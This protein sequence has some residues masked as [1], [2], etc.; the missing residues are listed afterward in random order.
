MAETQPVDWAQTRTGEMWSLSS[1]SHLDGRVIAARDFSF[2]ADG[3]KI[4]VG[5]RHPWFSLNLRERFIDA[6]KFFLLRFSCRAEKQG[7][8]RLTAVSPSG[9]RSSCQLPPVSTQWQVVEADLT[10]IDWQKTAEGGWGGMEGLVQ[11]MTFLA[12]FPVGVNCAV[13]MKD[14]FLLGEGAPDADPPFIEVLPD[15]A[16]RMR[17]RITD[18]S[19]V[20]ERGIL[21]AVNGVVF[22]LSCRALAWDGEI[23]TC[24]PRHICA[25]NL[26][27]YVEAQDREGHRGCAEFSRPHPR[28]GK[29]TVAVGFPEQEKVREIVVRKGTRA[30]Y[31]IEVGNSSEPVNRYLEIHGEVEHPK[32]FVKGGV[33]CETPASVVKSI[34]SPEMS[35]REKAFAIWRWEMAHAYSVGVANPVDRTKYMNVFGYGYCSSHAQSVQALCEAADLP[36][37]FLKYRLP[38]GHGTTQFFFDGGWHMLDSHQR[39]YLLTRDGRT[40]ASAE[41]IEGDPE[42][43]CPGRKDI[44]NY[45]EDQ[46]Y[47]QMYYRPVDI[48]PIHETAVY[49]SILPGSMSQRLR[50]GERLILGW[51]GEGRWAHAPCEPLD[52][53]NG[54][55]VFAPTLTRE[56]VAEEAEEAEHLRYLPAGG[57][58]AEP[59][60][61]LSYLMSSAYLMVGGRVDIC[62]EAAEPAEVRFSVS[63]DGQRWDSFGS[64]RVDG[65][66]SVQADFSRFLS[67]RLVEADSPV[68]RDV[69]E[70]RVRIEPGPKLWMSALAI[71]VDLQM[72]PRSLPALRQGTNRCIFS[73]DRRNGPVRIVHRWE[74]PAGLTSSNPSPSA[75]EEVTLTATVR[76]DEQSAQGPFSVQLYEG[77]PDRD[78]RPI[79]RPLRIVRIPPGATVSVSRRWTAVCRM[80]RPLVPPYKGYVHTD[81]FAVIS[82]E[83]GLPEPSRSVAHLRLVVKDRPRLE[84]EPNWLRWEPDEVVPG[85]PLRI[86]LVVWNG[87]S[88]KRPYGWGFVYLNGAALEDVTVFFFASVDGGKRKLLGRRL[89]GKI[90]P[91]EHGL[92]EVRWKVP[93]RA[94]KVVFSAEVCAREPSG[95]L[96][97]AAVR[98][99]CLAKKKG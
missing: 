72:H 66:F 79:G 77:H 4:V 78:G 96:Q 63:C 69:Y 39:L 46:R 62:G 45:R 37:M 41:Q 99:S 68:F 14:V 16:E 95:K 59:G 61:R 36:W 10:K 80:H 49:R 35:D 55:I 2:S 33:D 52:Y 22:D 82:P 29:P 38:T 13:Q 88:R 76:N 85:K 71:T 11:Q 57:I 6:R 32:V 3:L 47:P 9:E 73:C 12:E 17:F 64:V 54:K 65:R 50:K 21:V 67:K 84:V 1:P 15:E 18:P 48:N 25:E 75:G 8:F 34:L 74:E 87:S 70:C 27:V 83:K 26:C 43:I 5:M 56:A 51:Q 91:L 89:L 31:E 23:L 94:R 40:V 90:E 28:A 93:S 20:R 42:S 97:K 86:F 44:P 7:S 24:D 81:L 58:E 53:A 98:R 19:G 60:A 92:A 30:S